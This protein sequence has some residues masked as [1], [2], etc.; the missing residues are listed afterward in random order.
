MGFRLRRSTRLGPLRFNFA[1]SGLSSI[2]WAAGS[3]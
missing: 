3:A 1:K 2:R